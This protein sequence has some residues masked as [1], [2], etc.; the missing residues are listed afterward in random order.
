[1]KT[2]KVRKKHRHK[3]TYAHEHVKHVYTLGTRTCETH[4]ARRHGKHNLA[5]SV[6]SYKFGLAHWEPYQTSNFSH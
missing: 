2:S 1:M 4:I 6:N 3:G 5:H